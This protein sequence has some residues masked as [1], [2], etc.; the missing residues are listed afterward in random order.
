MQ[1]RIGRFD[2]SERLGRGILGTVFTG[3]NGESGES[4]EV[5]VLDGEAVAACRAL[6]LD[7]ASTHEF[8]PTHSS[9][10]RVIEAVTGPEISYV[11]FEHIEGVSLELLIEQSS[12][13]RPTAVVPWLA[14]LAEALDAM[15]RSG[16]VYGHL[17]PSNV[18]VSDGGEVKLTPPGPARIAARLRGSDQS[19]FDQAVYMAPEQVRGEPLDMRSDVYSVGILLFELL[20]GNRPFASTGL[21]STIADITSVQEIPDDAYE[22]IPVEVR[23]VVRRATRKALDDRFSSIRSLAEAYGEAAGAIAR[24]DATATATETERPNDVHQPDGE[25]DVGSVEQRAPGASSLT[26][27]ERASGDRNRASVIFGVV[28]A[29]G[30]FVFLVVMGYCAAP[31]LLK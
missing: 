3:R 31:Y 15:H 14:R 29:A 1:E 6:G 25:G 7:L 16:L 8:G 30:L 28:L 2:I 12:P 5:V 27:L 22:A 19:L 10:R 20:T 9:V 13:F 4:V 18:V 23:D 21:A 24:D 11:V 26:W 17:N